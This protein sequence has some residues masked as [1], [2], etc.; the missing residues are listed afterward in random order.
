[1]S[2]PVSSRVGVAVLDE[3]LE[4][5]VLFGVVGR[6]VLSAVPDDVDPCAGQDADGVGVV[7]AAGDGAKVEVGGPG[8]GA[9]GVAGEVGEGVAQVFVAGP[10]ESDGADLAGLS[11]R[12]GDAGQAGQRFWCGE[13]GLAV[14]DFGEQSCGAD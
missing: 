12:G 8:V 13:A 3:A 4:C 6:V 10:S 1:M 9:S 11:G 14:A 2:S 5:S 7:V